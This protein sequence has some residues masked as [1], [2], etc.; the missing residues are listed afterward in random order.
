[1]VT[2]VVSMGETRPLLLGGV[3]AAGTVAFLWL[4]RLPLRP[5]IGL[6][7]LLAITTAGAIPLAGVADR[8][9]PWFDYQA[10]AE[11]LGPDNP[12]RFD[13]SQRYGP[14]DW[15]RTHAEVVRVAATEPSYWKLRTLEEFDGFAWRDRPA[16]PARSDP[17]LDLPYTWRSH[18]EW[19]QDFRVTFRHLEAT[20]V[21]GAGTILR[22]SHSTRAVRPAGEP[23]MW[24]AVRPFESGDSYAVRAYVPEPTAAALATSSSGRHA[25]ELGIDLPITGG[26]PA[27]LPRTVGGLPV[28]E[29][30]VRF[31]PFQ[32]YGDSEPPSAAYPEVNRSG[33]GVEALQSSPYARTWHLATRLKARARTPY[34]YVT[35]VAAYLRSGF[36]YTEHPPPAQL[37]QAPLDA[38]L[39]ESR[40]GYCQQFAGAM[41][42]LLRMGGVPARVAVGFSPGGYSKRKAAW[43]VRDTDAH[44]WVEAW[45]DRFGWVALDPTPPATPARSQIA[46]L[47]PTRGA[48]SSLNGALGAQGATAQG[49]SRGPQGGPR[50]R[51]G[52]Q[53]GAGAATAAAGAGVGSPWPSL[54]AAGAAL[55]VLLAAW[56][57]AWARRRRAAVD[58]GHRIDRAIAELEAALRRSGRPPAPGLTLHQLERRLRGSPEAAAYLRALRTCRYGPVQALPLLPTGAQRRALRRALAAGVGPAARLRALWA[59]PPWRS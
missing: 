45:F 32:P 14:I 25:D 42:L 2:P 17:A 23:G 39:F 1:M 47:A 41:A 40:R 4:E 13:W 52:A 43:I 56:R 49:A 57:V 30:Q 33:N 46:S 58:G 8:E 35:A 54:P 29:A 15:P 18:P 34:D 20:E 7:A 50:E 59:L 12:L 24:R 9:Q 51:P 37:G 10:W 53:A 27:W 16:D 19:V 26:G 11:G 48:G 21:V 38:F 6:A 31:R 22:M 3:L 36:E 55:L 5:G 44:A 28:R